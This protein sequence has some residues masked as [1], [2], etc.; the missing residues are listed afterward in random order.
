MNSTLKA[1][2]V[3]LG[4]IDPTTGST[5]STGSTSGVTA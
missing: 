3:K 4:A 2:A 5:S 1:I